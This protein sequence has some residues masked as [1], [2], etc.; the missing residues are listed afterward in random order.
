MTRSFTLGAAPSISFEARYHI[1]P[2]WDYAYLQVSTDGTT[3]T[4]VH[5]SASDDPADNVNNQNF[6]EGISGVSGHPKA[7]DDNLNL[8]P[9]VVNVTADL[10]AWANQT[11]Q[12]RFRYW[13]DGAAVGEGIGID[14][15]QVTGAALDDAESDFGWTFDGFNQTDGTVT[16]TFPNYYVLEYRTYMGY[17]EALRE[18]PYNYDNPA[19]NWVTHFPYQDGLLVWYWDLSQSDNNV[20]LHP[21]EGYL[22]P[23]DASP[24]VKH[25]SGSGDVVRP[26]INS[27]D[28]TF[29]LG[30]TDAFTL[31]STT[32]GTLNVPAH[33]QVR[34]FN[35]N[36][37]YYVASDPADASSDW[38]AG[39][40]S[41]NHP[42]TGTKVKVASISANG[43]FMQI[44]VN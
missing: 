23:I 12:L 24:A 27:Y 25:W 22:L 26:R 31:T 30:R 3:W 42:H 5:T 32:L 40:N 21:G 16:S 38:K 9:E 39:W 10:S 1:E 13:T 11:V 18:G 4:N 34:T 44:V 15:I 33:R 28:A 2:C 8:D 35:D 43:Q 7:C 17:D 20:S 14:N 36:N 19:A 29:G 41:V 6:G 37:S